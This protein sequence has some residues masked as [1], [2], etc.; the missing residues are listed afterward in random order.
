[1][2]K[3]LPEM[4]SGSKEDL[5]LPKSSHTHN[6]DQCK[7]T[8]NKWRGFNSATLQKYKWKIRILKKT[9]CLNTEFSA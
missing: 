1:M 6:E 7:I 9:V 2:Q 3:N 8:S 5:L 4:K